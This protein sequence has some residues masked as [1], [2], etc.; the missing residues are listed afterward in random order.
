MNKRRDDFWQMVVRD[1]VSLITADESDESSIS[2]DAAKTVSE[3]EED[4]CH[5]AYVFFFSSSL[6]F[7]ESTRQPSTVIVADKKTPSK[8]TDEESADHLLAMLE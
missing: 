1:G 6:Q 4:G 7:L 5:K 3:E 2:L 8:P